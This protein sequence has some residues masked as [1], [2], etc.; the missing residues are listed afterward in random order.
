MSFLSE[1]KG[2]FVAAPADVDAAA[3]KIQAKADA[4]IAALKKSHAVQVVKTSVDADIATVNRLAAQHV[5]FLKQS[6]TNTASPTGASGPT[7]A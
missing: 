5:A 2:F 3:K 1:V 6:V 4:D 7:G